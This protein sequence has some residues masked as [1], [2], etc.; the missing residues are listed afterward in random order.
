MNKQHEEMCNCIYTRGAGC[1]SCVSKI[2]SSNKSVQ[3][4]AC[5]TT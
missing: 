3:A 5:S 4:E 2:G 1:Y